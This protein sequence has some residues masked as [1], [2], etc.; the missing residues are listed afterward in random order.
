MKKAILFTIMLLLGYLSGC[1]NPVG[2]EDDAIWY[3]KIS[4]VIDE[5]SHVEL[6]VEN[7]YQTK[8]KSLV[9]EKREAGSYGIEF[10]MVDSDGNR[11][12]DGIYTYHLITDY[13]SVARSFVFKK[14]SGV[15]Y[16]E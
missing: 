8:V 2:P 6:W 5:P 16:G 9:D 15:D 7:A 1:S 13:D 12:P 14:E 3:T 4:F 10:K 11:L